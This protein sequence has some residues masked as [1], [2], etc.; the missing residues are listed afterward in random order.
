[1][2]GELEGRWR[3][4]VYTNKSD[5]YE[6]TSGGEIL[7]GRVRNVEHDDQEKNKNENEMS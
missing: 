6:D 3:G 4:A 2:A 5:V 7:E 1:M